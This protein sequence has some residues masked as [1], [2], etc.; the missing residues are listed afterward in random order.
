[1]CEDIVQVH[2]ATH[3]GPSSTRVEGS[4]AMC[5]IEMAFLFIVKDFVCL[6]DGF[7]LQFRLFSLILGNFIRVVL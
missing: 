1:L 3:A 4:H 6:A 5:I 2:P 7:E